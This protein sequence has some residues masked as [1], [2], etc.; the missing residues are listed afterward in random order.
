MSERNP[1]PDP[2]HFRHQPGH[3]VGE[4][5]HVADPLDDRRYWL[6]DPKNGSRLL[7]V[8]FGLCGVLFIADFLYHR[9]IEHSWERLPGFHPLWGFVGVLLL[10]FTAKG[11]RKVV[12]RPEDYYDA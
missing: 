5:H 3:Q 12:M 4:E 1:H 10:V 8:F 11:L 9:H 7:M 2:E 6:D